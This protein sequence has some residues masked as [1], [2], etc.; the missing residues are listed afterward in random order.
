M[1]SIRFLC[2]NRRFNVNGTVNGTSRKKLRMDAILYFYS[3]RAGVDA[4]FR[5]DGTGPCSGGN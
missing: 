3:Q 5:L 1:A 4:E 2:L